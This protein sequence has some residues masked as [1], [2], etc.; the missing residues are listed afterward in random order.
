MLYVAV[1]RYILQKA[2][3][4]MEALNPTESIHESASTFEGPLLQDVLT[5]KG[6][7]L[8]SYKLPIEI[9]DTI[10][11]FAE[12]WPHTTVVADN[13]VNAGRMSED[14]FVIR[15]FPLGY[16]PGTS[17]YTLPIDDYLAA[18]CITREISELDVTKATTSDLLA[19]WAKASLPRVEHPCRKIVFTTKSKDQGWGGDR[20]RDHIYFGSYSWFDVGLERFEATDMAECIAESPLESFV[21][22][23]H[24]SSTGGPS[25]SCDLRPIQP[26]VIKDLSNLS[27]SS[28]WRFDHPFLP[29]PT[30]LQSNITAGK[31]VKKHVIKWAFDDCID[32]DAA[33]GEALERQGRGR[34]S[35]TGAYVRGLKL[36]D[37]VTVWARARFPGWM[38]AVEE[39]KIDVYWAV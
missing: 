20:G 3:A 27:N 33:E 9:I 30:K 25:I 26:A 23:F 36:G 28:L 6:I 8:E 11:D 31:E 1:G 35:G 24:L 29:P 39:V 34:E 7:L 14:T 13:H 21:E 2:K 18:R 19:Q 12:Y 4:A 17:N 15:S 38:N 5:V 10:I 32:P 37:I 16:L 22:K